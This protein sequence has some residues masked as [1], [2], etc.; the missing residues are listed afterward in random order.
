MAKF[1]N[2]FTKKR[3]PFISTNKLNIK[4]NTL[5]FENPRFRSNNTF[6][7]T[8]KNN[9]FTF[10]NPRFRSLITNPLSPRVFENGKEV[11][12]STYGNIRPNQNELESLPNITNQYVTPQYFN[13]GEKVEYSKGN[14]YIPAVIRDKYYQRYT[15]PNGESFKEPIYLIDYE[16]NK[17]KYKNQPVWTVALRK[18][19]QT[20]GKK[21]RRR[22]QRRRK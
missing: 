6:A 14:K 7:R 2:F 5:T 10:E 11:E 9:T 12:R 15:N 19:N 16:D 8:K 3:S 20:G 1:T 17:F 22:T 21:N 18:I 13:I 4:N